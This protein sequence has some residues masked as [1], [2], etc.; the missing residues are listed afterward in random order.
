M[1]E[2][3]EQITVNDLVVEAGIHLRDLDMECLDEHLL[4]F[5]N[6][7][8][9]YELVGRHL[10]LSQVQIS[11]IKKDYDSEEMKRIKVLEKWK[12]CV[13]MCTYKKLVEAFLRC[14]MTQ[15]ALNVC[16]ELKQYHSVSIASTSGEKSRSDNQEVTYVCAAANFEPVAD[17]VHKNIK[18][19][20]RKLDRQFSCVQRQLMN[21][22]DVTLSQLISCVATLA[23][24]S[25][26]YSGELLSSRSKEEFFHQLKKHCNAQCPD[27]LEDLIEELGDDEAKKKFSEFKQEFRTFQSRTKLKDLIGKYEGP[28]TVPSDYNE[29][30]I[31]LGDSWHEKA[32]EDL[33]KLRCQ[34]SLRSWVLKLIGVGSLTVTCYVHVHIGLNLTNDLALKEMTG[35]LCKQ[36]VLQI[37]LDQKCIFKQEGEKNCHDTMP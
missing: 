17:D 1:A 4:S 27:I 32:L 3:R 8:D 33:E 21:S 24:F 10:G 29:L 30:E 5:A 13:L 22:P 7:C 34:M 16:K 19:S 12:Q 23:S 15:Q 6:M 2:G 36:D 37:T 11:D 14:N 9:P 18:E 35:Y 20:L 28:S 31:K 25:A 26:E